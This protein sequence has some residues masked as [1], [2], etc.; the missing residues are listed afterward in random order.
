M[1]TNMKR[2][3]TAIATVGFAGVLAACGSSGSS[4]AS[5]RG[6]TDTVA[7][8]NVNGVGGVLVDSTGHT[9]YASDQE[10]SGMVL[11][12]GACTAFWK[13]LAPGASTPTVAGG[14]V[15][16]GVVNR[17]DG[18]KQVTADGR[19]LYTFVQDSSGQVN[20]N[21]FSDSFGSQHFTWHAVLADG[22]TGSATTTGATNPGGYGY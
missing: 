16:L 13:P 4:S 9:L 17:P 1:E 21:G 6:S 12:T 11:C 22:A 18:A 3:I 15:S 10:A 7:V 2:L 14:T 5:S 8:A 20:G 19:P